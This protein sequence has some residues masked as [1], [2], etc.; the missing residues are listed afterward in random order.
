MA[1]LICGLNLTHDG[2]IAVASDGELP[3]YSVMNSMAAVPAANGLAPRDIDSVAADGW[4]RVNGRSR[5]TLIG[6]SGEQRLLEVAGITTSPA[7]QRP[8]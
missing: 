3:R 6:H 8:A 5:V 1:N 2:C 4:F 7:R